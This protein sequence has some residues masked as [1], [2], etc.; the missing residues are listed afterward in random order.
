MRVLLLAIWLAQVGTE[1]RILGLEL[2]RL[3]PE[4]KLYRSA[5]CLLLFAPQSFRI[6]A[7][8]ESVGEAQ[9]VTL[10]TLV[11]EK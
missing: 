7:V 3:P 5:V 2:N 6:L 1:N 11:T 8:G 4:Y 9:Y 10:V